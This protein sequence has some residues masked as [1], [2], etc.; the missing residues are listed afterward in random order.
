MFAFTVNSA[1]ILNKIQKDIHVVQN[2]QQLFALNTTVMANERIGCVHKRKS[3]KGHQTKTVHTLS[4]SPAVLVVNLTWDG[5]PTT[6]QILKLLLTIP[7][8]F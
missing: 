2:H 3:E 6:L 7:E 8:V 1:E 5:E 4:S